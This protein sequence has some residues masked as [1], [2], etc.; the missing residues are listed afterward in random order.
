MSDRMTIDQLAQRSGMTARNIRAHQTRGLLPAPELEGRTGF[1]NAE[2]VA[3][4]ELIKDMQA[5]GFNLGAIKKLLDAAPVGSGEEVLRFERALMAPWAAEEPHAIEAAELD[6]MLG[7]E[8]SPETIHR[9]VAL[10]VIV[11][12]ADG[13]YEVPSPGLLRAGAEVV[14]LGIPVERVIDVFQQLMMHS[15][16]VAN[17][18]VELFLNDVWRPFESAGSPEE[19]WPRV[20]RSL[21]Q[22]RPLAEVL[23]GAF[24]RTMSRTVEDAFGQ[25]L[26]SGIEE[27]SGGV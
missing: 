10:G 25:R 16:G 4:L 7:G 8:L 27:A 17:V 18:F 14:S 9:A 12:L 11:E 1:Y 13:R 6:T 26:Q 3:R 22:L 20:R 15:Q 23:L 2:H 24:H 19:E 21:E 5:S